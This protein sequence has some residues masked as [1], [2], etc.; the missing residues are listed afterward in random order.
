[1][2]K[3]NSIVNNQLLEIIMSEEQQGELINDKSI[4]K[5]TRKPRSLS[6]KEQIAKLTNDVKAIK[7]MLHTMSSAL[8][9]PKSILPDLD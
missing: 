5:Q 1:M 4:E 2:D 9:L 8:G 7:H 6:D 3:Q